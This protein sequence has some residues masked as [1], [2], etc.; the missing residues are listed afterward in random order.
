MNVAL[1]GEYWP[2]LWIGF[3]TTLLLT[4]IVMAISTPL[5]FLIAVLRQMRAPFIAPALTVYVHLFRALPALIVLFFAFYGLPRFGLS[6][7]PL[8]AAIVGMTLT[9]TAYFSE[10]F[11][12]GLNAIAKGQWDAA[13]ALGLSPARMVLRIILPQAI[14][15]M[16]PPF[17][18]NAIVTVKATAIAS[19]VGVDELTGAAMSAMSL[20]YSALDFLVVA[21]A[22]YL[23]L[24]AVL[25]LFQ[26]AA[27]YWVS[28]R[29][30]PEAVV[31]PR[32]A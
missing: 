28:R 7:Q 29:Y 22:L 3:K 5:A 31:N 25:A 6:L 24:S 11:R 2:G 14:P 4:A 23:A 12:A 13:E 10:D 20:T 15:I 9:S 32:L 30:R 27:E 21:A 1:I 18:T 16:I 26:S 8:P 17:M 19:L